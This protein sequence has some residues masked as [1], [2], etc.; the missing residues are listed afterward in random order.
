[1]SVP[2]ANSATAFTP[3]TAITEIDARTLNE[4]LDRNEAVLID[5][6]EPD[7]HARERLAVAAL[8]PL[9]RLDPVVVAQEANGSKRLV[10]HCKGGRRSM[11]AANRV[12]QAADCQVFSLKGGLEGWKAAGLPVVTDIKAPLPI[13]RQVQITV[14]ASVL[15]A[16][17]LAAVVSPWFLLLTAFFGAG[18]LFA[19]ATGQCA[20]ATTL[21]A[22]PWN[23][24]ATTPPAGAH[25]HQCCGGG[26][27]GG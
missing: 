10:L 23:R 25:K 27:C 17:L 9:S 26:S 22:M 3:G 11:E 14:G 15:I 13:M 21:A 2:T 24:I 6:R 18:L 16:T 12:V 8:H 5:V 4:W 7:E 19:G 1:M 20:L